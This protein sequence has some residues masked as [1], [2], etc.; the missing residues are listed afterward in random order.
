MWGGE[1]QWNRKFG[2]NYSKMNAS[3]Y[4]NILNNTAAASVAHMEYPVL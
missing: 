2:Q 3:H 1:L 4:Q